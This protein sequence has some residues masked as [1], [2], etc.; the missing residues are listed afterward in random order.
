MTVRGNYF[1]EDDVSNWGTETDAE[2]QII[3]NRVEETIESVTHDYFYPKPFDIY[4]D[5]N[6]KNRLFLGFQADILHISDIDLYGTEI[7]SDW[8]TWDANCVHLDLRSNAGSDVE[9]RY[10]LS[11]TDVSALFP[12]GIK[13]IRIQGTIGWPWRMDYDTAVGT[14][15]AEEIITSVSEATAIIKEVFEYYLLLVGRST[16]DFINDEAF[17]GGTSDAT[18]QVNNILGTYG[19][20]PLQIVK[21]ASILAEREIDETLYTYYQKGN[22]QIG[23]EYQYTTDVEPLTNIMEADILLS[24]FVRRK[25]IMGAV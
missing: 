4:I 12:R 18:A 24:R 3:I 10:L 7:S 21:A 6:G 11:Q 17:S 23:R 20:P 22:E 9:L 5:G 1:D 8:W 16:A 14:F 19:Y 15:V 13:N 2:K 25:P